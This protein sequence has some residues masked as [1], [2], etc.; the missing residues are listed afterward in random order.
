M[1]QRFSRRC[2]KEE[3][4]VSVWVRYEEECRLAVWVEDSGFR[5]IA[6]RSS[7]KSRPST[8]N[9]RK[10]RMYHVRIHTCLENGQNR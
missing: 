10:R 1:A 8:S 5:S 7:G 6:V 3:H 9:C 4:R 2:C